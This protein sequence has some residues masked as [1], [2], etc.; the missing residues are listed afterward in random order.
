MI[1]VVKGIDNICDGLIYY[2]FQQPL[3]EFTY[4]EKSLEIV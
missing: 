4:A 2:S 1:S 3:V